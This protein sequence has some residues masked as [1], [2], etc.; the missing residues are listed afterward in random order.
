MNKITPRDRRALWLGAV[1]VLPIIGWQVGLG[2][3]A[4]SLGNQQARVAMAA[5]LLAREQALVRDSTEIGAALRTARVRFDTEGAPLLA[6]GDSI[7]AMAAAHAVLRATARAA[8]LSEIDIEMSVAP[9]PSAFTYAV[10][11]DFRARGTPTALADWIARAERS[12]RLFAISRLDVTVGT[13]EL[14]SVYARIRVLV[15]R[16]AP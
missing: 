7:A 2:P 16:E 8:E 11:A 15:R 4:A 10:D 6:A 5:G 14:A 9:G 1:L 13:D 3:L 12:D